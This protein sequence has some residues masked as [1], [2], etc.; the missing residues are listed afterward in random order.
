MVQTRLASGVSMGVVVRQPPLSSKTT[1]FSFAPTSTT[2]TAPA[3]QDVED[4]HRIAIET[5]PAHVGLMGL[6]FPWIVSR[7]APRS[8]SGQGGGLGIKLGMLSW[9]HSATFIALPRDRSQP[10]NCVTID[11]YGN[12]VLHYAMTPAD[13]KLVMVGLEANLRLMRAAGAKFVYCAHES[14]PWHNA[15]QMGPRDDESARFEAYLQQVHKEGLQ[16]AKMQ[17]FSAHQLSS[18][19]MSATPETGPVSPSG[20]LWECAGVFVADGSVLPTSLGINPMVTIEAFAHM[21]AGNV[22]RKVEQ[23]HPDMAQKTKEFRRARGQQEGW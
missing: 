1:A 4:R 9:R 22:V 11:S 19:R 20:E 12:P 8:F 17:I 6:L 14:L 5:P 10:Q 3:L 15:Q 13:A 16:T 2:T 21:I 23:E 7:N 18:C